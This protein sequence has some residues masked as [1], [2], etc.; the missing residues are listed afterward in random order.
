VNEVSWRAAGSADVAD[1]VDLFKAIELTAPIGLE[2]EPGE[3]AE[4]LSMPRM[5]PRSD[6]LIGIDAQRGPVAYAEAA[7]MGTGAGQFRIRLTCALRP[8]AGGDQMSFLL[9]WLIERARQMRSE[10]HPDLPGVAA[11]RCAATDQAR[12]DMLTAAGFEVDHWHHELTRDVAG[13]VKGRPLADGVLV[14][15]YDSQYCEAA[16][17]AQNEA[18]A[19]E[20]H[21]RLLDARE[22]PRYAVGLT[23]FLP[24]ASFL[25]LDGAASQGEEVVAFLLSLEHQDQGGVRIGT[26]LSLGT[27]S[28]WR[29]HGLATALIGRA[30]TE[31]RQAGLSTAR[32]EVCSHNVTAVSLYTGLG[33]AASDRG[34]V[35]L[36]GPIR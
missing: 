5:D 1:L 31:Y 3:V 21:G 34:Y 29:G 26:L 10:R 33:F 8:G 12:R 18:F 35:V 30:L 4:R 32:L 6:T 2:A 20:P 7:D 11:F 22:W 36:V 19:D 16:R 25:A 23:T 28:R 27:R 14:V 24:H 13:P 17:L 9:N 15:P